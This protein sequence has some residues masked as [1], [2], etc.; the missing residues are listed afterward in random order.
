MRRKMRQEG[1]SVF[2]DAELWH[3]HAYDYG[4]RRVYLRD[5]NAVSPIDE[6]GAWYDST[7]VDA[8]QHVFPSREGHHR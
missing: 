4:W 1:Y 7:L 3:W 6:S 2:T 8:A 5:M